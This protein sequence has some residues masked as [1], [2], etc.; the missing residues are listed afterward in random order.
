MKNRV[1]RLCLVISVLLVCMRLFAVN[2]SASVIDSGSCG[3]NLTWSLDY[4]GTLTISGT[5]DMTNYSLDDVAP[6]GTN[7][8]KTVV[9][10]NG[11]TS[12]GDF[13][14]NKCIELS[15]ITLSDSVTTIGEQAFRNCRRLI[16]VTISKKV[17]SIGDRAF[18]GCQ[19]LTSVDVDY[20][21]QYYSSTDGILFNKDK[22]TLILFP[23]AKSVQEYSV[24]EEVTHI[25]DRAFY[26]CQMNKITIGQSVESIGLKA[27]GGNIVT[28]DVN[29][30][31]TYYSSLDGNLFNKDKTSLIQYSA[32]KTDI[33]YTVPDSVTNIGDFAFADS[34]YLENVIF[35]KNVEVIGEFAFEV[36]DVL[37]NITINENVS[38]ISE[39]AFTDCSQLKTVNY[40]GTVAQFNKIKI[41]KYNA[42]LLVADICY[43]N[44]T[45]LDSGTC[46]DTVKWALNKDGLLTIRG[47]GQMYNYSEYTDVPWY[48]LHKNIISIDIL[49]GVESVGDGAFQESANL[50]SVSIPESVTSIGEF[51]FLNCRYLISID[52]PNSITRV[53]RGAFSHCESLNNIILSKGM[54]AIE[55]RTFEYCEELVNITIPSIITD[56]GF[57][58][59]LSCD[60]L[61]RVAYSGTEAQWNT[62]NIHSSNTKLINAD[63]FFFNHEFIAESDCFYYAV[64][65]GEACVIK[66]DATTASGDIVIPEILGGYPVTSIYEDAFRGCQFINNIVIPYGITKIG[67]NAFIHCSRLLSITISDSVVEIEDGAFFNCEAL[68]NII[69]PESVTSIEPYTFYNCSSL[70]NIY[71]SKNV[72]SIKDYAFYNC[73]S[74]T[75]VIFPKNVAGVSEHAFC[76][77]LKLTDIIYEGDEEQWE[78][79]NVV[80]VGNEPLLSASVHF[81]GDKTTPKVLILS[82]L[83]VITFGITEN[84]IIV[85]ACYKGSVMLDVKQIEVSENITKTISEIGVNTSGADLS[86]AFLWKNMKSLTPVCNAAS[87]LIE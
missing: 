65:D 43:M 29:S 33:S 82:N 75:E 4:S 64:A 87:V 54:T 27:F 49:D 6:W 5:G 41:E 63:Y 12:I 15:N 74:L 19:K 58:A 8:V 21:N 55:P 20:D 38:Q 48:P 86:K 62:I 84:Y 13:A 36:C 53:G 30:N 59:F 44:D 66:C 60:S 67:A 1:I 73:K 61:T 9:I 85:V 71:I 28:I 45:I 2:A 34:S 56:I 77:C 32:G 40:N 16:Q 7:D 57:N 69:I 10:E 72:T 46:G 47:K 70:N 22:T 18:L 26:G 23:H 24:P 78:K 81:I 3:E 80:N 50:E 39:A 17:T 14:F 51:A 68:Q 42:P 31:N 25:A 35:G 11:V 76:N 37:T 79:L 52:I 83:K